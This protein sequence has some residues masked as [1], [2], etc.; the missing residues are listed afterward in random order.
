MNF[1]KHFDDW[2]WAVALGI[3]ALIFLRLLFG[4]EPFCGPEEHCFREWVSA[5]GSWAAIPAAIITVWYLSKQVSTAER[6]HRNLILLQSSHNLQVAIA[7]RNGSRN[8]SKAI[9]QLTENASTLGPTSF[10][11][12]AKSLITQIALAYRADSWDH[13]ASLTIIRS[14]LN[15][16]EI[17]AIVSELVKDDFSSIDPRTFD[18]SPLGDALMQIVDFNRSM[19]EAADNFINLVNDVLGT[20]ASSHH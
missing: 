8:I 6:H 1:R 2:G 13:F 15:L 7:V 4:R 14:R 12:V 17:R 9:S 20:N 3:I 11:N 19:T 5:T 16:T 10:P 18:S